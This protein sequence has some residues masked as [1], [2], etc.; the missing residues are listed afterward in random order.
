MIKVAQII[1]VH[2][3]HILGLTRGHLLEYDLGIK[4]TITLCRF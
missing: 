4:Q 3:V 2:N 1:T